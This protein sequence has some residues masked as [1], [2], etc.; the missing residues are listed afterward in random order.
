MHLVQGRLKSAASP[1]D[2]DRRRAAT[3]RC[4][5]YRCRCCRCPERGKSLLPAGIT[6]VSGSFDRGDLVTVADPN[7]QELGRGLSHYSAADIR[8]IAGCNSNQIQGILGYRGRDE[9]IHADDLVR[10]RKP[11][12]PGQES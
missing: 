12:Q 1:Q 7:G 6:D 2:M 4:D 3:F 11:E 10:T 9:V 8:Q 5:Q